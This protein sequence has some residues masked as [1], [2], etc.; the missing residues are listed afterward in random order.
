MSQEQF[1]PYSGECMVQTIEEFY[2]GDNWYKAEI[3]GR[4]E[5][6]VEV[7]VFKWTH[8]IVPGYGEVCAPFWERVAGGRMLADSLPAARSVGVEE[9]ERLSGSAGCTT[10]WTR[11]GQAKEGVIEAAP[12]V[13]RGSWVHSHED[14]AEPYR[15]ERLRGIVG[16]ASFVAVLAVL[17]I[18]SPV[19][20]WLFGPVTRHTISGT[21]ANKKT[22]NISI[23]TMKPCWFMARG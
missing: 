8:E 7:V 16:M 6:V 17:F 19:L 21:P 20:W 1:L 9:L 5:D 3:L 4:S 13:E 10:T 12:R 14:A 11:P 22:Q 15:L 18:A 23:S 2:S